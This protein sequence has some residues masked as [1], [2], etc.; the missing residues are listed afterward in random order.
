MFFW[1]IPLKWRK[2]G[3]VVM[4]WG[5]LI[6]EPTTETSPKPTPRWWSRHASPFHAMRCHPSLKLRTSPVWS[7]FNPGIYDTGVA[8]FPPFPP[9]PNYGSPTPKGVWC[10][11]SSKTQ[12]LHAV[13][14]LIIVQDR[15]QLLHVQNAICAALIQAR[16]EESRWLLLPTWYLK[17]PRAFQES[18]IAIWHPKDGMN[19]RK[20]FVG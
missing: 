12:L 11:R 14:E 6:S 5:Y 17:R 9:L 16:F 15:F 18:W 4:I 2:I 1:Y 7:W 8:P 13:G 10:S 19:A 3:G 20:L